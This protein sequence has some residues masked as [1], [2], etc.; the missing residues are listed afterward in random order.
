M[1]GHGVHRAGV[2]DQLH[3][4]KE[5]GVQQHKHPRYMKEEEQ[6]EQHAVNGI[7]PRDHED[8]RD[9]DHGGEIDEYDFI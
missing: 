4:R 1:W 5:L 8:R 6:H 3:R 9:N 2:N 7:P